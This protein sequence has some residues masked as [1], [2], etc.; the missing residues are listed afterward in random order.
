MSTPSTCPFDFNS[1]KL[2]M[3][4]FIRDS[5]VSREEKLK[6]ASRFAELARCLVVSANCDELPP[7][8]FTSGCKFGNKCTN[9]NCM[10]SHYIQADRCFFFKSGA[11]GSRNM[12][13][14]SEEQAFLE[15]RRKA[16]KK[17]G[18]KSG[19]E[20]AAAAGAGS[21]SD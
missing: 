3:S 12:K 20:A 18:K 17:S 19:A 11:P 9:R 15:E 2:I 10:F 8:A 6:I 16:R 4:S 5:D 7:T 21:D 1:L 14:S 13:V